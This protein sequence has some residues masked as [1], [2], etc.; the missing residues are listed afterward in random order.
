MQSDLRDMSDIIL[1]QCHVRYTPQLKTE[2][3]PV[4][5]KG[6][7]QKIIPLVLSPSYDKIS[8]FSIDNFFDI[9]FDV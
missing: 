6:L 7:I 5:V 9:P 8:Y 4:T 3:F 1:I 2:A